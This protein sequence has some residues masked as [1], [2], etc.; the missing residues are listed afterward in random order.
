MA[1]ITAALVKTTARADRRRNDGVQEALV[2]SNGDIEAASCATQTRIASAEKRLLAA[3]NR[4]SSHLRSSWRTTRRDVE[5]NC[6]SDFVARTDD[7][8][9]SS[10]TRD[11]GCSRHLREYLRRE[12]VPAD[13]LE[14][15]KDINAA[16]IS[17]ASGEGP[18]KIVEAA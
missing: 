12:D 16:A 18:D 7:F 15:E 5:V 3:P 4:D 1:E 17:E 10:K 14:A 11:A 2:E 13:V 9:N 8:Q 6:E